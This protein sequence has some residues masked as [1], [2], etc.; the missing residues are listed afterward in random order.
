VEICL[1]IGKLCRFLSGNELTVANMQAFERELYSCSLHK[2]VLFRLAFI[3]SFFTCSF[4]F[5]VQGHEIEFMTLDLLGKCF[6][7]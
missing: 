6:T 1:C 2:Y 4:F 3:C 7:T 5:V